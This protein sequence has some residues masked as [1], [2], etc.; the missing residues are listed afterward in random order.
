MISLYFTIGL[1]FKLTRI[2]FNSTT[3]E[4]FKILNGKGLMQTNF[5]YIE[6]ISMDNNDTF[7]CA[8]MCNKFHDCSMAYLKNSSCII[9]R[10]CQ[11]RGHF[12]D[13]PYSKIFQKKKTCLRDYSILNS[14]FFI[15]IY[16]KQIS[17]LR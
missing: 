16:I 17:F 13:E 8:I 10:K 9:F 14:K 6:N 11:I 3:Q 4:N 5:D 12:N 15:K 1:V 7:K 2:V